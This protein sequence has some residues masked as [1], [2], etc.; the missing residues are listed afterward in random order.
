MKPEKFL[1]V[2]EH[3]YTG[4]KIVT[5]GEFENLPLAHREAI[6]KVPKTANRLE[7]KTIIFKHG[8]DAEKEWDLWT[9]TEVPKEQ[10]REVK[11]LMKMMMKK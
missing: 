4:R 6:S 10:R 3:L 7:W 2:M 1:I 11:D 8:K 5:K 9:N